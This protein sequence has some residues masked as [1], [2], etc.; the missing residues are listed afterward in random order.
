MLI[1]LSKVTTPVIG[2]ISQLLGWLMNGIYIVLGN[3][4]TEKIGWSI[5]IYTLIVYMVMLPIQIRTQKQSKM[6]AYMQPEITKVQRKYQGRRD[7][8]SMTR[9]NEEMQNVYAKYG[10]SPYGTCLPLAFQMVL[11]IGVYQV[12]YHIPGYV[13]KIG[14]MFSGLA[15]KI[16]AAPGGASAMAQFISDNRINVRGIGDT[17]SQA[18]V[19]DA[20]YLLKPSQWAM[21]PQVNALSSLSSEMTKLQ[22]DLQGVNYFMGMNIS[23]SP[24]DII[25]DSFTTHS[26]GFLFLAILVPVLAWLTQWVGVKLQPQQPTDDNNQMMNTMKSMNLIMPIFSAMICATLSFGVGIYWIAGAVLRAVQMIFINRSMMKVDME[27][28][29]KKNLEKAAKKKSKKKKVN[30][31]T[32]DEKQAV[33]RSRVNAQAYANRKGIRTNYNNS[34]SKNSKDSQ[35]IWNYQSDDPTSMFSKANMV[36]RYNDTH[37]T[38]QTRSGKGKKGKK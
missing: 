29:I 11:L 38:T 13:T 2:W 12:I 26:W 8:E 4:G 17:L 1:L 34:A 16:L 30:A 25:K 10:F 19:I 36:S 7:Q 18:N 22:N 21:L 31:N 27:E 6:Q 35:E 28:M 33:D 14:S 20:L 3:L 23:M 37:K 15:D 9:M 5:I 24:W 32:I